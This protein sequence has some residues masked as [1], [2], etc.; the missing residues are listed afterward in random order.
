MNR[1]H[2]HDILTEITADGGIGETEAILVSDTAPRADLREDDAPAAE[3][4]YITVQHRPSRPAAR[5]LPA[6]PMAAMPETAEPEAEYDGGGL[7]KQIQVYPWPYSFNFYQRFMDDARRYA[8]V[9]GKEAPYVYFFSFIPQ[10][11]QMGEAQL[12]YYLYFREMCRR[13]ERLD[14]LEFSYILLY[15]YELINLPAGTPE[16]RAEMLAWI[17]CTYRRPYMELDKYLS[18][19]M[20]DFC[21]VHRIPLPERLSGMLRAIL[22]KTTLKE[23]YLSPMIPRDERGIP[24]VTGEALLCVA[25]EYDYRTSRYYEKYA[26]LYDKHIPAA[27][28]FALRRCGWFPEEKSLSVVRADRD[29][30]CGTL[31]AQTVKR[32]LHLEYYGMNLTREMQNR[33]M[34]AA[35]AA[36]NCLRGLLKIK[37]RLQ[38]QGSPTLISEVEVYFRRGATSE[39]VSEVRD[40][41]Q[42]YAHL[43]DAP[44]FGINAADARRLEAESWENTALLTDAAETEAEIAPAPAAAAEIPIIKEEEIPAA[45]A[46]E[47]AAQSDMSGQIREALCAALAGGDFA[48]WCRSRGLNP[49]LTAASVNDYA[50]DRLGDVVL[51]DVGGWVLIEDYREEIASWIN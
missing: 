39:T 9:R 31:C 13:G 16:A 27:V 28:E 33:V 40:G 8:S 20:C 2:T 1:K 29:A 34:T 12:A 19:W 11:Y 47:E 18:E 14:K 45:P 21:I 41:Q 42:N 46:A 15:I 37:S 7:M 44:S 4:A 51:E 10:Y 43:Y 32:R 36:E 38:L 23:F 26:E 6:R 22:A 30:F 49:A 24:T 25:S 48:A 5:S 35:K 50:A 3:R 17:W